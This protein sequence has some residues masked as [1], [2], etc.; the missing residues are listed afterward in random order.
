MKSFKKN[1]TNVIIVC[2]L[3]FHNLN[4]IV[5]QVNEVYFDRY[6]IDSSEIF[7]TISYFNNLILKSNI[8]K[9]QENEVLVK[10]NLIVDNNRDAYVEKSKYII[11]E[12][13]YKNYCPQMFFTIDSTNNWTKN[14]FNK[15]LILFDSTGK[16]FNNYF[17]LLFPKEDY[18][19]RDSI[20]FYKIFLSYCFSLQMNNIIVER[21]SLSKYGE[22]K[23]EIV[24]IS[25][26]MPKNGLGNGIK[27][28]K[29][30]SW[31]KWFSK[32]V[33]REFS[34]ASTRLNKNQ[35]ATI[36]KTLS[37]KS[38]FASVF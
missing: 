5:A 15:N 17:D 38:F 34:R 25:E 29:T 21:Q 2:F 6:Y 31:R 24:M 8:M 4:S 9:K 36:F 35:V 14:K 3:L 30:L 22:F 28:Y 19:S 1:K 20:S 27:I 23:N 10:I 7:S 32:K 12:S 37:K 33:L 26:Y 16:K 13:S 11:S 18:T